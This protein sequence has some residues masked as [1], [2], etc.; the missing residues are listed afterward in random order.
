MQFSAASLVGANLVAMI[1]GPPRLYPPVP[2]V[3][4]GLIDALE[5]MFLVYTLYTIII[6]LAGLRTKQLTERIAPRSRFAIVVPAHNEERVVR[7]LI[8]SCLALDYPR[9]LFDIYVIADNCQDATAEVS[10]A[11][12]AR[13]ITRVNRNERGK[14]YA[15]EY[16]FRAI[17][18]TGERY[19]AYVIF[20]ADNLVHPDFLNVMNA[21]LVRGDQIIQ[22]RMDVKNPLDTWVSATFAMSVWV[23]N[24]FWYMAKY[25]LGFSAVL[26][27]T[28]MCIATDLL[29]EIGWGATCF[30]EDL[31][32]TMQA[33]LRGVKTVWAHNAICYDEK[34]QTFAASWRQRRRWVQGQ[35]TV[36]REALGPMWW[37]GVSQLSFVHLESAFQIFQPLYLLLGTT[38]MALGYLLPAQYM[39]DPVLAHLDTVNFW[40]VL[41]VIEYLMPAVAMLMDRAPL[42]TL[43]YLPL[44]PV[45]LNSWI[46]LTWVGVFGPR[47]RHWT[48]TEHTRSITLNDLL[49]VR[50]DG[51]RP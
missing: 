41:M 8:A 40:I 18:A 31:Q 13:V 11:A 29:H 38:L 2:W 51:R 5:W 44:Y 30:T 9:A 10:A 4:L 33:L 24:R 36:V 48:H 26:G 19:E 6:P 21:H 20:D 45:F 27:G 39:R 16:A 32:F 14:G 46:P 37:R 42:R 22:G 17:R 7:Q 25:N 23:S 12:G 28:G 50:A 43:L 34:V 35:S 1:P 47:P 3:V 15:L 49:A